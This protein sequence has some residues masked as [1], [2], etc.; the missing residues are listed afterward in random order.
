[1]HS[2]TFF[3]YMSFGGFQKQKGSDDDYIA[4]IGADIC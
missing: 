2:D 1:M 4:P 3:T